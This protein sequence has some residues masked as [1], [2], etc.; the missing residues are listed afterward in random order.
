ML[1]NA[2]AVARRGL[3]RGWVLLGFWRFVIG[4]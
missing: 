4:Q 3:E 1:S 2:A